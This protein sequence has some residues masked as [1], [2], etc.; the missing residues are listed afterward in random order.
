MVEVPV[1]RP[2]WLPVAVGLAVLALVW[3]TPRVAAGG[4]PGLEPMDTTRVDLVV[5]S[6]RGP[7]PATG[8]PSAAGRGVETGYAA[9][10]AAVPADAR[11]K[12][13]SLG[14]MPKFWP[15]AGEFATL[16]AES[17]DRAAAMARVDAM[18]RA[19]PAPRRVLVYVHGYKI[20][21]D[22]AV[23][24]FAQVARDIGTPVVPV[25]FAWPS[26]DDPLAYA[27]DL[28]SA[29]FSRGALERTLAAL[30]DL[31]HVDEVSVLAHSM[32]GWIAMEALTRLAMRGDGRL[33]AKLSH[34]VL[35]APDLD[36]D[37]FLSE[38]AE[39]RRPR[40]SFTVLASGDDRPLEV[41]RQIRAGVTRLGAIDPAK[42][43][44]AGILAAEGVEIVDTTR[45]PGV[46]PFN[47]F[48][49]S[50]NAE[51]LA[52]VGRRVAGDRSRDEP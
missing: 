16:A 45:L 11:R 18:A 8:I 13:A 6:T 43:P 28:D 46:A 7:D 14:W 9:V 38:L 31:P 52:L 15:G 17:L 26:R 50:E 30:A 22:A 48:K 25:V 27:Y 42:E 40:P 5:V 51:L 34:V 33:P 12:V 23:F 3:N 10:A 39:I 44:Y 29:H 2:R 1:G 36:F 20:D 21:F 19:L 32:G 41:S 24:R 4:G 35:A 47:H 49:F 37:V